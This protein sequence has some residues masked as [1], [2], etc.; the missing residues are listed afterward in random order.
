LTP[1]GDVWWED[2]TP[3]PP[4]ELEDWTYQKW[5]PGC[6]RK[7]AHPNARYTVPASQCPVID[8]DWERPEGVPISA[9]IFG[10]RRSTVR[11]KSVRIFMIFS[12]TKQGCINY[13]FANVRLGRS[14]V[15]HCFLQGVDS[16]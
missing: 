5:T 6:G 10:G 15:D 7:A 4:A 3:E 12:P 2:M 8:P 13:Q 14:V 16:R 11:G 1:E 9:I